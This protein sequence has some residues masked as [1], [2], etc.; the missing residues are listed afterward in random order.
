M[1]LLPA[2]IP[3]LRLPVLANLANPPLARHPPA[4]LGDGVHPGT[5]TT[6]GPPPPAAPLASLESPAPVPPP[7]EM[8]GTA[9]GAIPAGGAPDVPAPL[10]SPARAEAAR[11]PREVPRATTTTIG[12]GE[13]HPGI[14]DGMMTRPPLRES[15]VRV[16]LASPARE[17]PLHPQKTGEDGD[18]GVLRDGDGDRAARLARAARDRREVRV[19]REARVRRVPRA[20]AAAAD[21]VSHMI[22]SNHH[23]EFS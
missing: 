18:R 6:I 20:Q 1:D 21:T 22:S 23:Y 17:V 15:R 9:A 16:A 14:M 4:I 5:A 11:V 10:A 8:N 19:P 3:P 2:G 7:R 13:A 12:A